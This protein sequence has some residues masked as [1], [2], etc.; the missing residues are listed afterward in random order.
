M[1]PYCMRNLIDKHLNKIIT[2]FKY[3]I[4]IIALVFIGYKLFSTEFTLTD[5]SEIINPTTIVITLVLAVGNWT[6]EILKWQLVVNTFSSISFK[7]A[8]FQT[9]VSYTY[10]MLTPF[11]SGNYL[12]KVFFFSKKHSKSVVFLNVMKGIYQ[13]LVTVIFGLWGIYVILDKIDTKI[14]DKQKYVVAIGL[15]F[16]VISIFF[17]KKIMFYLKKLTLS[18]HLELFIYSAIKFLFFS[19]I[20]IVLFYEKNIDLVNLYA[21]ICT[22]YLLSSLLPILNILD[23]AIKGSMALII[24]KPLGIDEASILISYFVLWIL[25]HA[26]P[27]TVGSLLQLSNTKK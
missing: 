8:S 27:A 17:R 26:L 3:G 22:V 24:L 1:L 4:S 20:L 11:N 13:M 10:G 15:G 12:K 21:G 2:L 16:L 25:N 6:F 7:T 9:L 5:F 23:F 18:V 14:L 19:A